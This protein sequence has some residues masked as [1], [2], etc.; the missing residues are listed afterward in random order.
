MNTLIINGSPNGRNGN[1]EILSQ[2]FI[3]GMQNKPEIQY[4]CEMDPDILATNMNDYDSWLFFFPMYVNAMP[5]IV[6]RLFEHLKPN[7]VKKV[8]YFVQ[9]GF[10]ESFQSDWL[11]S[12]LKCF[13]QRMGFESLG[14]IVAGGMAGVRYM[15]SFMT[16]KT[17][18]VMK[19]AGLYYEKHGMF[20]E[21]TIHAFSH[22][23]RYSNNQIKKNM[24]FSKIGLT[25]ITWNSMLKSNDAYMLRFDKPFGE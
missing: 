7:G 19:K 9:Y 4:I 1:T 2:K 5:G 25:N 24:F 21:T 23:Y 18:E 11:C 3:E 8:G 14:T 20:D 12:I 6:K 15:P 22:L 13:D 16:K 17:F 10:E